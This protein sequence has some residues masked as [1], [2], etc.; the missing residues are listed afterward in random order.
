MTE[1]YTVWGRVTSRN[2][3]QTPDCTLSPILY[4]PDDV[5]P[6]IYGY[7]LVEKR[8]KGWIILKWLSE[9]KIEM[10]ENEK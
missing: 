5:V 4:D 9:T 2:K 10:V 6:N 7:F 8:R 3:L 1:I